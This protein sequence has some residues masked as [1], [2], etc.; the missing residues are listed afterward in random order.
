VGAYFKGK[1]REVRWPTSEGEGREERG[2]G[3]GIPPP[4][5]KVSKADTGKLA[6]LYR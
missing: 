6:T 5:V 4:K 1:R 2:D 3:K